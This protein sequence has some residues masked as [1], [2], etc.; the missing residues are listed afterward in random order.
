MQPTNTTTFKVRHYEC[1]AFGHLNH[2]NYL[3][4]ME[5]AAFDA[6]AAVGYP[7]SRY[8][9]IGYLWLA[10][11]TEIEY[12]KPLFYGDTVEIKTWV[13]DFRRVRSIR[14]Y[15]FRVNGSEELAARASTDWVYIN[16]DT[17]RPSAVPP[18][19]VAAFSGNAPVEEI[20]SGTREA[21]P[22]PPPPPHQP[23]S[24]HRRVEWRDIDTAQH[25][26][27][28]VYLNYVED[29]GMQAA[30]AYGWPVHRMQAAGW[31]IFARKERIEYRLPALLNDELEIT[32]WAYDVKRIS[33]MR[34]YTIKRGNELLAQVQSLI[35]CADL[36]TGKPMRIPDDF[37]ND[38][39]PNIA[40][41]LL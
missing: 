22:A 3:H 1:D 12:L 15:E 25:V 17:L 16:R 9:D 23:F 31:G 24:I 2:V 11:E 32:T 8:E 28:A 30:L 7:K 18:E 38:V 33:A 34:H 41:N 19:M 21:F 4:Y 36:A 29:C 27:N 35:V 37:L 5:E 39:A 40:N 10:R 20:S 13:G 26:N 6:S 14:R